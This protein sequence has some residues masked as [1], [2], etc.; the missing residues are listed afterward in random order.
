MFFFIVLDVKGQKRI[1]NLTLESQNAEKIQ[2][3]CEF[4]IRNSQNYRFFFSV[5]SVKGQK[6]MGNLTLEAQNDE[7]TQHF[8][9]QGSN[10]PGS[11]G[12]YP[13]MAGK[14]LSES[15]F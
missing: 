4:G 13:T 2:H 8:G 11:C 7:K 1:G 5:L 12:V 15:I 14:L 9:R 3:F 6:R 10:F